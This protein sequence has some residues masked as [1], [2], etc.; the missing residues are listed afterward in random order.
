MMTSITARRTAVIDPSTHW[1]CERKKR[2]GGVMVGKRLQ[3]CMVWG[4]AGHGKARLLM[5]GM[6]GEKEQRERNVFSVSDCRFH[7][8]V[9]LHS[10]TQL[11]NL[12]LLS[13]RERNRERERERARQKAGPFWGTLYRAKECFYQSC[14]YCRS[15]SAL[16]QPPRLSFLSFL[17]LCHSQC[18]HSE[19]I[20]CLSGSNNRIHPRK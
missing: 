8:A 12:E 10:N 18:A 11:L 13:D 6:N 3:D 4:R 16:N 20:H 19:H 2:S 7:P 14:D 17:P 15:L 5:H 9:W 1:P